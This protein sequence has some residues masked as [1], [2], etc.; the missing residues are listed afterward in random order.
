MSRQLRLLK[1]ESL[2]EQLEDKWW[3]YLTW[4]VQPTHRRYARSYIHIV[5]HRRTRYVHHSTPRPRWRT[6]RPSWRHR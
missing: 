6:L 2:E 3:D 4:N 5:K 1:A